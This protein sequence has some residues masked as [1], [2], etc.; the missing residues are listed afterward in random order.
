MVLL[1]SAVS[2]RRERGGTFSPFLNSLGTIA[3]TT[4]RRRRARVLRFCRRGSRDDHWLYRKAFTGRRDRL[5]LR[6]GIRR[7]G[8]PLRKGVPISRSY[9][10]RRHRRCSF[11]R[12]CCWTFRIDLLAQHKTR[13]R[14]G[15][16]NADA[17]YII[18]E[19]QA[20]L[21]LFCP[22]ADVPRNR[23]CVPTTRT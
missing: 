14:G 8:F 19:R 6:C 13:V 9:R 3:S 7:C 11:C 10:R 2:V 21:L 17:C 5:L 4:Y 1:L 16:D 12:C 18:G 23:S 20:H 15:H 22:E